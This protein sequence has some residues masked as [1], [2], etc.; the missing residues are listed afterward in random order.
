VKQHHSRLVP[1]CV[2][3]ER[4]VRTSVHTPVVSSASMEIYSLDECPTLD[5]LPPDAACHRL[6]RPGDGAWQ[7][8]IQ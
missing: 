4:L 6:S 2:R 5:R 8:D 7:N 1:C 3:V